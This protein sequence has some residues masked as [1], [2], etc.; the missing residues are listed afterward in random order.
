MEIITDTIAWIV[1]FPF[2]VLG[3]I[4]VGAIA[5]ELARRMMGSADH[6]FFADLLLGIFGAF[7]GGF[8]FGIIGLGFPGGGLMLVLV[9]LVVATIGAALM[10]A[11]GR[12]LFGNGRQVRT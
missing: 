5:G 12:S 7:V 9:N 8:I 11:L 4:V 10:I 3:W 1:K 2:V 6:S